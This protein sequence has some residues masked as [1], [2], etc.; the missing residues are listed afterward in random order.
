MASRAWDDNRFWVPVLTSGS[1]ISISAI[2]SS[3]SSLLTRPR[4]LFGVESS[5]VG[6]LTIVQIMLWFQQHPKMTCQ[7]LGRSASPVLGVAWVWYPEVGKNILYAEVG[8]AKVPVEWQAVLRHEAVIVC[9]ARAGGEVP[10]DAAEEPQELARPQ[11]RCH[12]CCR[13]LVLGP[14]AAMWSR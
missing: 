2:I 3:I 9:L 5:R 7:L 10:G 13:V 14:A 1:V 12:A 11:Y 8:L 6:N 4:Y